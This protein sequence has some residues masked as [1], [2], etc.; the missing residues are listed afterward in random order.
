MS[1]L[2][3]CAHSSHYHHFADLSEGI[4]YI[5]CLSGIYFVDCVCKINQLS[6]FFFMRCMGLCVFSLPISL[7][8]IVRIC[9]ILL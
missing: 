8:M 4:E 6:Q 1:Y 3:V 9:F 2:F 7:V 5:K